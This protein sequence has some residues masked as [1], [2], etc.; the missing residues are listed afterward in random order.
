MSD[1]V[2]EP[3]G[4]PGAPTGRPSKL[5]AAVLDKIGPPPDD[6]LARAE[7]ASSAMAHVVRLQMAGEIG[8]DYAAS[9]R[10]SLRA[11]AQMTPTHTVARVRDKLRDRDRD[12]TADQAGPPIEKPRA[13][14][15]V[16]E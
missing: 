6:P 12:V 10:T 13:G 4:K 16:R 8:A 1:F 7:W 5:P 15:P 2:P 9:L 3:P 14:K 11:L